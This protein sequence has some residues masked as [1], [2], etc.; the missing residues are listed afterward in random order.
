[1]TLG[2]IVFKKSAILK[3]LHSYI[4]VLQVLNCLIDIVRCSLDN[5]HQ[6]ADWIFTNQITITQLILCK[7]RQLMRTHVFSEINASDVF[8]LM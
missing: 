1:M 4:L 3:H 6:T 2:I 5:T 7:C 8:F